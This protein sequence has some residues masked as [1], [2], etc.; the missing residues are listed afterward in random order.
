MEIILYLTLNW[1]KR[2]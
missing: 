1:E 2:W